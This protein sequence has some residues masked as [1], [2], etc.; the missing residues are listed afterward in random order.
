MPQCRLPLGGACAI[1]SSLGTGTGVNKFCQLH[2]VSP[3]RMAS[4]TDQ[5]TKPTPHPEG[6]VNSAGVG[7]K[8]PAT[9]NR[10]TRRYGHVAFL[11]LA[12]QQ[13]PTDRT[14]ISRRGFSVRRNTTKSFPP[15]R[16]GAVCS[17]SV[18]PPHGPP[19]KTTRHIADRGPTFKGSTQKIKQTTLALAAR[20]HGAL[21]RMVIA[22][23][24]EMVTT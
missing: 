11:R 22:V 5:K 19:K 8:S 4:G 16:G 18:L 1:D 15:P 21:K 3:H 6:G 13:R 20:P 2:G 7:T 17:G 14:R 9:C 12:A 24:G 23:P 10:P